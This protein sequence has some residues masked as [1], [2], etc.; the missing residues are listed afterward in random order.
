MVNPLTS[1]ELAEIK[2]KSRKRGNSVRFRDLKRIRQ[3]IAHTDKADIDNFLRKVEIGAHYYFERSDHS[4][5]DRFFEICKQHDVGKSFADIQ[6]RYLIMMRRFEEAYALA[7]GNRDDT[8]PSDPFL[9]NWL[10]AG[11]LVGKGREMADWLEANIDTQWSRLDRQGRKLAVTE[12]LQAGKVSSLNEDMVRSVRLGH[13]YKIAKKLGKLHKPVDVP[14]V[15]ISLDR[16]YHRLEST[17][18]FMPK[19][20]RFIHQRALPGVALS[21][22]LLDHAGIP[23]DRRTP[24]EIGCSLS[25]YRAWETVA[26][27]CEPDEYALVIEDDTRFLYGPGVGLSLILPKAKA[28]KAGIVYIN[29]RAADQLFPPDD[30]SDFDLITLDQIHRD[31][32]PER[33]HKNPGWGAD[34]YLLN[35]RTAKYLTDIWFRIGLNGALDWQLYLVGN[36]HLDEIKMTPR[37]RGAMEGLVAARERGDDPYFVESYVSPL[38]LTDAVDY[39]YSAISS[40]NI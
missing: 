19:K 5:F 8:L 9:K 22:N 12:L 28:A 17:Q 3:E 25:H 6:F 31:I 18:D 23:H 30:P 15:A 36:S 40:G 11:I 10:V 38:S 33:P 29:T 37:L 1:E 21:R 35:G 26:Q 20:S 14:I 34:A 4:G 13:R 32:T 7:Q 27:M 39:G 24:A 2:P 16:D